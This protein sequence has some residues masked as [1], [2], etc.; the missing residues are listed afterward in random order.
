VRRWTGRARVSLA[1]EREYA[2]VVREILAASGSLVR[3]D[4]RLPTALT[5]RVEGLVDSLGTKSARADLTGQEA[6]SLQLV[7][8]AARERIGEILTAQQRFREVPQPTLRR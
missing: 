3:S 8:A 4:P 1:W 6:D 7:K 5:A 2:A